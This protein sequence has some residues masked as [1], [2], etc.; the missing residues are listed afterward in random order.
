MEESGKMAILP[1]K[2]EVF[3]VKLRYGSLFNNM[4]VSNRP[5]DIKMEICSGLGDWIVYQ[6]K[7]SPNVNWV[8]LASYS[9]SL[10]SFLFSLPCGL[11]L[12]YLYFARLQQR[13]GTKESF[14]FGLKD[15]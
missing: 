5:R 14:K 10:P 6:A 1:P 7:R 3:P 9:V 13:L 11:L 2:N 12:L 8:R 4:T 15:Y